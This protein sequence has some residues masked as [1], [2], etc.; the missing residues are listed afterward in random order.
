MRH[1]EV[2]ACLES[3]AAVD[4][5][6]EHA[7]RMRESWV[8]LCSER[9]CG[10]ARTLSQTRASSG[11]AVSLLPTLGGH[12]ASARIYDHTW[13]LCQTLQQL[14]SLAW[15]DW[16]VLEWETPGRPVPEVQK[17]IRSRTEG[18][19]AIATVVFWNNSP[20]AQEDIQ[21]VWPGQTYRPVGLGFPGLLNR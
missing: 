12:Q 15:W 17:P 3:Q 16:R 18:R 5:V 6:L 13:N 1:R 14:Q 19:L 21:V 2:S 7:L 20:S 10:P 11:G 8:A 9:N 4:L